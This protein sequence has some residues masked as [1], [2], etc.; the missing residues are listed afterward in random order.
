MSQPLT[1]K[2]TAEKYRVQYRTEKA[3]GF[4]KCAVCELYREKLLQQAS[5]T[6]IQDYGILPL[7][8][9]VTSWATR[10][11]LV[12]EPRTDQYTTALSV[13]KAQ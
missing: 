8:Y 1:E 11:G 3:R 9:E 4:D 2:T 6:V 12:Y 13:S 5:E 10:D 7:H